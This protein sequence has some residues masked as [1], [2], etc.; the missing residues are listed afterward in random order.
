MPLLRLAWMPTWLVA[1]FA[2]A[3]LATRQRRELLL[4]PGSLVLGH[5]AA[6]TLAFPIEH[7][8]APAIPAMAVMAG[9]AIAAIAEAALAGR[10]RGALPPL[11]VA[12]ACALAGALPPQPRDQ[13]AVRLAN[14]AV[15]ALDAGRLDA[16][17][18][19]AHAALAADPE[20]LPAMEALSFVHRARNELA[21]ARPWAERVVARRPWHPEASRTLAWIDA[22]QGRVA[23][24]LREIEALADAFPW[25]PQVRAW[26]GEMRIFA[27]DVGGLGRADVRAAVL[28]GATVEDW[29]LK[30]LRLR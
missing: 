29:A 10:P 7:F 13:S 16:A 21:E 20:C 1:A 14:Q 27:G 25:C 30:A 22:H 4:G 19:H 8:R 24:A 18:R 17:E 23:E 3:S 28:A 12:G 11:L 6:C 2:I 9:C 5:F 26:R 15:A